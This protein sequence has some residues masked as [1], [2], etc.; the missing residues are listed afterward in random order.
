VSYVSNTDDSDLTEGREAM[1]QL[2]GAVLDPEDD[3]GD[4]AWG[5]PN[6][7][8]RIEEQLP[9]HMML[10]TYVPPR[11]LTSR[12]LRGAAEYLRELAIAIEERCDD[13]DR[14]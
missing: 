7:V 14:S 1:M 3:G 6:L 2:L 8:A 9:E 4:D 11:D 12:H 5:T 10:S 13:L